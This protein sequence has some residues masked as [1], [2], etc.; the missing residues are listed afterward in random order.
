MIYFYSL[1]L[2]VKFDFSIF[3]KNY[4]LLWCTLFFRLDHK[5]CKFGRVVKPVKFWKQLLKYTLRS[6][7]KFVDIMIPEEFFF[8]R[9]SS[10]HKECGQRIYISSMKHCQISRLK[11]T[12]FNGRA[13]LRK[14]R[15]QDNVRFLKKN[16]S[17]KLKL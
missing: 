11:W 16:S 15:V 10:S 2:S 17:Q 13:K 4:F 1:C 8:S 7:V 14:K 12:K 3:F 9:S 6:E 5:I